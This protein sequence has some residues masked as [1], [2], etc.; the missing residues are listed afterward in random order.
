MN[1]IPAHTKSKPKKEILINSD[2]IVGI[3][4]INENS[5]KLYIEYPKSGWVICD[6]PLDAIAIAISSDGRHR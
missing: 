2:H 6:R 5:T 4:K 3:E 1:W